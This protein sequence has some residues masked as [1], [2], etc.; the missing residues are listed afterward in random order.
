MTWLKTETVLP[1]WLEKE[2][3]SKNQARFEPNWQKFEY[4]LDL[5]ED[6]LRVYL[7]TYFP[8]SYVEA[9]YYRQPF[10][11]RHLFANVD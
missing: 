8:R 6:H 11:K 4:N 9:F 2:L 10:S 3:F 7:G 1:A 5:T